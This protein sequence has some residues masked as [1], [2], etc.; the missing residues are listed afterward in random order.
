MDVTSQETSAPSKQKKMLRAF[1]TWCCKKLKSSSQEKRSFEAQVSYGVKLASPFNRAK[2]LDYWRASY[3][4]PNASSLLSGSPVYFTIH[5]NPSPLL[6]PPNVLPHNAPEP[7]SWLVF[8]TYRNFVELD[9]RLAKQFPK[10]ALCLPYLQASSGEKTTKLLNQQLGN[11]NHYLEN[12]CKLPRSVLY[13]DVILEYFGLWRSDVIHSPRYRRASSQQV[14]NPESNSKE[15]QLEPMPDEI[16]EYE[17]DL[18]DPQPTAKRLSIISM[19]T[20][21]ETIV[22]E[23]EV[24]SPGKK[25]LEKLSQELDAITFPHQV[26]T[27]IRPCKLKRSATLSSCLVSPT[28]TISGDLASSKSILYLTPND[29]TFLNTPEKRTK[30]KRHSHPASYPKE[31]PPVAP[32]RR[33]QSVDA[34]DGRTTTPNQHKTLYRSSQIGLRS[35]CAVSPENY[36][37]TTVTR[38]ST[39]TTRRRSHSITNAASNELVSIQLNYVKVKVIRNVHDIILIKVP[40]TITI[41]D[42]TQRVMAKFN[43]TAKTDNDDV[44]SHS[45]N[46]LTFCNLLYKDSEENITVIEQEH[47]QQLLDK[48]DTKLT[49]HLST[50]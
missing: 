3:F 50:K 37:P 4:E 31:L 30:D 25:C 27:F 40:R 11:L 43:R 35:S 29:D 19:C 21:G 15:I 38:S 6:L 32:L 26:D 49:L 8:R 7:K 12:L 24:T 39:M 36:P 13:S 23:V 33:S 44:S 48:S 16:S 18:D 42:F 14:P 17:V 2:V 45:V 41:S 46:P 34:C 22:E 20:S 47:F 5:L 10:D 28:A 1:K 9:Q